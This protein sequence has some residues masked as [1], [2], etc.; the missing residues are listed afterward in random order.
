MSRRCSHLQS[1]DPAG[2]ASAP[3][4]SRRRRLHVAASASTSHGPLPFRPAAHMP[5]QAAATVHVI[6]VDG[7]GRASATFSSSRPEAT[8]SPNLPTRS[9]CRRHPTRVHDPLGAVLISP[10][11]STGSFPCRKCLGESCISLGRGNAHHLQ[12]RGARGT[13]AKVFLISHS[14]PFGLAHLLLI[15]LRRNYESEVSVCLC[16]C[17]WCSSSPR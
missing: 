12:V 2:A 7:G 1:P 4:I 16:A 17:T 14:L 5:G 13:A 8:T 6:S 15:C 3:A 10:M 11:A 9:Q